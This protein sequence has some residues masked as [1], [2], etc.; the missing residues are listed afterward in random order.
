MQATNL[1]VF[2]GFKLATW[3]TEQRNGRFEVSSQQ[4]KRESQA[5]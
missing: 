5:I 4:R 3:T 1:A 2:V